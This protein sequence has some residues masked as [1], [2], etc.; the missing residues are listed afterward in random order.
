MHKARHLARAAGVEYEERVQTI[1]DTLDMTVD[2]VNKC[3][4]MRK[5]YQQYVSLNS[6][7]DEENMTELADIIPDEDTP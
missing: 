7:V 1:A 6:V 4:S 5:Q 2:K 3:L